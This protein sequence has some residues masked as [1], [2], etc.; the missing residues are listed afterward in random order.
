MN[1]EASSNANDQPK[2]AQVN[3]F[4]PNLKDSQFQM[5]VSEIPEDSSSPIGGSTTV[6]T[7]QAILEQV[8]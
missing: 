5:T 1:S 6:G 4:K 7:S 3:E 2:I 8:G